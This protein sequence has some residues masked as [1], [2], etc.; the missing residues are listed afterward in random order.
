MRLIHTADWHLGKVL[1][2]VSLVEDQAHV[3]DQF[4]RCAVELRPD[5]II[6]AGDVFDRAIP[7]ADAVGLLDETLTR[8][9]T[10]CRAP[11]VV[12][13]GNHDSAERL[14]FASRMLGPSGIHIVARLGPGQ[15][16][17]GIATA[18]G[19]L[20]VHAFPYAEPA[21]ARAAYGDE[22]IH[23]HAAATRAQVA[24]SLAHPGTAG[25]ARIAVAHVFLSGGA[26]SESERP[27][28]VGGV[29]SVPADTF[30]AFDYTALGHLHA[31]QSH[32]GG[33]IRYPGSLLR[34]SFADADGARGA[35]LVELGGAG[36]PSAELIGMSPRRALR[37]LRGT[38][39]ELA[40]ARAHDPAPEDYISAELTD[41]GIVVDAMGR[42]REL[43]PNALEVT[44]AP[45]GPGEMRPALAQEI[46]ATPD[47]ELFRRFVEASTGAPMS[48]EQEA[49]VK[50]L[51][52]GA[53]GGGPT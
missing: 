6:L 35:L 8:L 15:A 21:M 18:A 44:F 39:P 7:P 5:A 2:G 11:I 38:L 17:L 20:S 37:R 45:R 53:L 14:G 19:V 10:E 23:S 43:Y 25:V 46:R 40:A 34:Y 41:D 49:A 32:D 9:V 33:R 24:A 52:D 36:P 4:I 28:S 22:S 29:A 1:R 31:P 50:P 48:P 12:I 51:L 3:L 30:S 47:R 27:L 16:P 42:L 26:E 13:S